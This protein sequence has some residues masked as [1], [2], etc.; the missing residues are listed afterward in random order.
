MAIL[1]AVVALALIVFLNIDPDLFP[2]SG[3]DLLLD[4]GFRPGVFLRPGTGH[5]LVLV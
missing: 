2:N 4:A 1:V 5:F 3:I